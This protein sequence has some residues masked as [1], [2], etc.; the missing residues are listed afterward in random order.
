M[1][2]QQFNYK[3]RSRIDSREPGKY[4]VLIHNDDFTTMDIVVKILME[5]FFKSYNE[6][7][8]LML[9]VHNSDKAVVVISRGL[10]AT[11][12]FDSH[13]VAVCCLCDRLSG[14]ECE[15]SCHCREA[16]KGSYE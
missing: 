10:V 7:T 9:R 14:C 15:C 6:A 13:S 8:T 1:P 12:L 11:A 4:E 2:D 5:V 3:E 16:A